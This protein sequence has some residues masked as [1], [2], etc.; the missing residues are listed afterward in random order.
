MRARDRGA[1]LRILL[2]AFGDP[3]HAFPMIAL[4]R[5]LADRGHE[6]TLQTWTRWQEHVLAEQL[7]FAPAPGARGRQRGRADLT[8]TRARLGLPPHAHVHGGISRQL[9]LVATFPQLEYPRTWAKSAHVV[10]PLMWEP[11]ARDVEPPAGEEP[12]VL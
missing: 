10:G 6:V 2:G 8:R 3:G 5:A 7:R 11:R 4:G 9:A 1:A 12:L